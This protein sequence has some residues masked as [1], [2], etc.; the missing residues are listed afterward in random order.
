MKAEMSSSAQSA[1]TRSR[2]LTMPSRSASR[3]LAPSSVMR[4]LRAMPPSGSGM[5][6]TKP[7]RM[8]AAVCRLRVDTSRSKASLSSPTD[9]GPCTRIR[10]SRTYALRSRRPSLRRPFLW[11]SRPCRLR[12][13]SARTRPHALPSSSRAPPASCRAGRCVV[14]PWCVPTSSYVCQDLHKPHDMHDAMH[15]YDTNPPSN[16]PDSRGPEIWTRPSPQPAQ[17]V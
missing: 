9:M 2:E 10:L 11:V 4:N 14:V 5:R 3:V 6:S 15:V 13:A 7:A 8:T 1:M 17:A 16:R 12:A